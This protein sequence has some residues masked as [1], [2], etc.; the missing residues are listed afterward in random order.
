MGLK[1]AD[2]TYYR[3]AM[4]AGGVLLTVNAGSR[5]AE[6]QSILQRAGGELPSESGNVQS[7]GLRGADVGQ[8]RTGTGTQRIQLLGEVLR[9]QKERVKTGSV[10]LRKDVVSER[11][12]VEVPV[13][14]EELI[15]ERHPV[16]GREA[17]AGNFEPGKQVTIDLEEER[18]RVEKQ[19]VVREEVEVGKR[20]VQRTEHVSENVRRENLEVD[21][22]GEIES[23]NDS[24]DP[25]LRKRRAS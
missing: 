3:S 6:V 14:R 13:T 23:S 9:V 2:S 17:V 16:K 20:Q 22:E 19:P 24:R 15:I 10:N 7:A 25:K 11:Q 8:N 21:Q 1:D 5:F 12:D 18:V 4:S